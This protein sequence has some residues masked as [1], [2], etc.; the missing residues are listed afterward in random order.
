[1]K[2]YVNPKVKKGSKSKIHG[3]GLLAKETI[4]KGEVIGVKAGHILLLEELQKLPFFNRHPELQITETLFLSPITEEE[5]LESMMYVNHGCEPNIGM[6][7]NI[8]SVAMRDINKGEELVLDYATINSRDYEFTCSCGSSNCRKII[9][10]TDW[11]I[12]E[13]QEKYGNYFSSYIIEKIK[14]K[15]FH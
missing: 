1:M 13:L 2:S 7:G 3:S 6:M 5:F 12:P 10:G 11:Q 8:V 14:N 9:R 15:S 4:F